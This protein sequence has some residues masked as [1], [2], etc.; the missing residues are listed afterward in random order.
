[1]AP[2]A[3]IPPAGT[4]QDPLSAPLSLVIPVYNRPEDI[5]E[6]L[7][8][9]GP[10]LPHLLEVLVVDDG[11][12]DGRTP[13]AAEAAIAALEAAG[14]PAG[15]VR[16]IRQPNGGP[17]AARNTGAREARGEWLVFLDSDDFW[18]PWSGE[19]IA[20][21]IQA[22]PEAVGIFFQARPF[23]RPQETE[24]WPRVAPVEKVYPNFFALTGATPRIIRIGAGYFAIRRDTFLSVD[25]FVPGLR[26]SEDSDFYY[27]IGMRG[28]FVAL[29]EPAVIA[30]RTGG[31]DSLTLNMAALSEGL[32]F[33]MEG[34]RSGRYAEVPRK[35]LDASL[36][37]LLA[38]WI[39]ALFW[40]GWGREAYDLLLRQG[41]FGI[42]M[43][44]GQ[45]K[46]AMKLLAMPA[47]ATIRPKNHRFRWRPKAGGQGRP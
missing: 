35:L 11:S 45:A 23:A 24:A 34:R 21:A 32:Y 19:V 39:H 20:A 7:A 10:S 38:F 29:E 17:G 16:L 6:C 33:L 27:R 18:L 36:S 41:G 40:G 1:M 13:E 30:R 22:H 37:D 3:N 9:L 26:G 12:R 25:G 47:L 2:P 44:H 31:D 15:Q 43:R 28:Q 14:A 8:R 46:A 5:A 4:A 42:M